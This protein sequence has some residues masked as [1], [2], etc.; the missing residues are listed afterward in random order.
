MI[1]AGGLIL[2]LLAGCEKTPT[3]AVNIEMPVSGLQPE[4]QVSA[5][6]PSGESETQT[7]PQKTPDILESKAETV[8][9]LA[10]KE[11]VIPD[12]MKELLETAGYT[13]PDIH[14]Q[15]LLIVSSSGNTADI[16]AFAAVANGEWEQVGDKI[17]GHTGKN[18]VTSKKAEGDGATPKGLYSLTQAFGIQQDPG[19][20]LPYRQVNADS[21]WVDDPDSAFYNQWVDGSA[22]KDWSSAEHL[23]D[24]PKQYAY[25]VVID[26]NTDPV[27]PGAGSAIFLHCG[28]RATAGCVSVAQLDMLALLTWLDPSRNPVILIF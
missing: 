19:C 25:A 21:Y 18:G 6:V 8:E 12:S 20:L 9:N 17:A 1:A 4:V 16:Y 11:L 7:P 26:Y 3:E 24:Y 28:S 23:A 2:L 27:E 15:Q 10:E 5:A 22:N 13:L 14:A